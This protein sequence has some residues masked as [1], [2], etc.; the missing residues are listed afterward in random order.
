MAELVTLTTPITHTATTDYEVRYLEI[1]RDVP[2]VTVRLRDNR[3]EYLRHAYASTTATALIS[4]L[5]TKNFTSTSL[6]KEII[7]RLQNDGVIG[8]GTISGTPD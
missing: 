3:G 2:R 6:Q 7:K 1:D 8:A 4:L 5:N